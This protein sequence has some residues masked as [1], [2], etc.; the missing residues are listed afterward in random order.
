MLYCAPMKADR[1]CGFDGPAVPWNRRFAPPTNCFDKRA[2]FLAN[3]ASLYGF[4][5]QAE[6]DSLARFFAFSQNQLS[7]EK[8]RKKGSQEFIDST[9]SATA[10]FREG[11]A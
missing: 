8:E 2:R 11:T 4:R 1:V 9:K 5:N 6:D 7:G 10:V 3:S